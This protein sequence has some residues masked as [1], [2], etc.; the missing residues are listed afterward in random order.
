MIVASAPVD[1]N[2][3]QRQRN[4]QTINRLQEKM[5]EKLEDRGEGFRL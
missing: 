5:L 4:L 3:A 1:Q 2:E